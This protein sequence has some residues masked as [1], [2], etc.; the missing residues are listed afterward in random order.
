MRKLSLQYKNMPGAL[1][2]CL[3]SS[4]DRFVT[5]YRRNELPEEGLFLLSLCGWRNEAASW[6]WPTRCVCWIRLCYFVHHTLACSY[7][8]LLSAVSG[9]RLV[10]L[11]RH[12]LTHAW[13]SF[14]VLINRCFCQQPVLLAASLL[15][16]AAVILASSQCCQRPAATWL[17]QRVK[18]PSLTVQRTPTCSL[19][20]GD[21]CQ[22]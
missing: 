6:R 21:S 10:V 9:K 20:S 22:A 18:V 19:V 5:S 14:A 16:I 11:N 3:S 15:I 12:A 13:R 4:T 7:V 17:Q 1:C 8:T 2:L